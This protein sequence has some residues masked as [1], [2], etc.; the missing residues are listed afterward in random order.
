MVTSE[1]GEEGPPGPLESAQ[2]GIGEGLR[3][4]R[5]KWGKG[6]G[7]VLCRH[8]TWHREAENKQTGRN[9]DLSGKGSRDRKWGGSQKG[10]F[11]DKGLMWI[12]G[13]APRLATEI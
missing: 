9:R 11:K 13:S 7:T 2:S 1:A 12:R 3:V 6:T 10:T 5:R 4:C 8:R